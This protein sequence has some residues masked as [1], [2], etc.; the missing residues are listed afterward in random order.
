MAEAVEG[1]SHVLYCLTYKYKESAN[2]RLE[3][4]YAHQLGKP[5]IPLMLEDGYQPTGWL[6]L[7]TGTRLWYGFFGATLESED[8]FLSFRDGHQLAA[9]FINKVQIFI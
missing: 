9:D 8:K 3:A 4:N 6:G 1:A 5:M 7:L 2:C